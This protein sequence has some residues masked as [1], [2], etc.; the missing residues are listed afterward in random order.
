MSFIIDLLN[1]SD[2][3]I[4][5]GPLTNVLNVSVGEALDEAG[6]SQC[7]LPATDYRA[8]TLIDQAAKFR[9][10]FDDG[11][12]VYGLIAG[13]TI[14]AASEQPTRQVQG[15]DLLAE[16][17]NK[18]IGWWCYYEA[19]DI[20]T[21]I[22]PDVLTGTNWSL[23]TVE[24][25]LG[26]FTQRFDGDSRLAA[27]IK[28]TQQSN[29]KHFRQ[30]STRRTLDF[31]SFGTVLPVRVTNV[32]HA[33]RAQDAN[34]AIAIIGSLQLTS[35]RAAVV[36]RI[37]PWGAGDDNGNVHREK[38]SLWYL[39]HAGMFDPD[40]TVVTDARWANIGIAPGVRGAVT[41][42]T[43]VQDIGDGTNNLYLVGSTA[44]FMTWPIQQLA[45][46]RNPADL[47]QALGFNFVPAIIFDSTSLEVHGS[48]NIPAPAAAGDTLY[49][50]PQLYLQTAD[51]DPNDPREAVV[52]FNDVK[53][54]SSNA[55]DLS[56]VAP[57]LYLRAKRYLDTHSAP[58]RTYQLSVL[59]APYTLRVGDK[60]RVIYRGAVTRRGVTVNWI[61]LDEELY[62]IKITRTF[63]AD[64][65]TAA[66]LDVSNIDA[67][68]LS[69]VSALADNSGQV[70]AIAVNAN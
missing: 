23:G 65:S 51:Y 41:T 14:D 24:A 34:A 50:N 44:G 70:G 25:G 42:I 27:L 8:A 54:M 32:Q 12:L 38:V 2:V 35:D 28:L 9:V 29:G 7:G 3:P 68:P 62:L 61:D 20:N 58:Q 47:T 64:G 17:G 19:S 45:W 22:L 31:G 67:Q 30:G 63:N 40:G 39:P 43:N 46:V 5:D 56:S 53:S 4:G 13:D 55:S 33:L 21:V 36:H 59:R 1:G 49:G 57:Q 52:I 60:V 16:L 69:D 11:T 10:R 15:F 37:Y 18:S 6:Q 66:T 26:N 48:P